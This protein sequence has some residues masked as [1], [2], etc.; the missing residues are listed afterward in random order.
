[1]TEA[2]KEIWDKIKNFEI[3]DI[4]S[5]FTFTNRL[6]RENDWSIEYALRTILEYKKF[7][8]LITISD[9]PQTP[10]DQIDQVWHLHLLYTE[11]Y[12]IDLC[13]NTINKSIHHGPTKGSEEKSMF[14]EQY[15][16]TLK[17]YES[18]F[19]E[20]PP[21]DIWDN[22]ESRFNNVRFTR[23]NRHKNWV[24]PKLLFKKK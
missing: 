18:T 22:V 16:K 9:F 15:L 10:S 19:K 8:F 17:F 24:I 6:S 13:K 2:Q 3:D 14:K 7:I 12:W 1:M 20:K 4:N 11:S 23:I 21:K 5:S